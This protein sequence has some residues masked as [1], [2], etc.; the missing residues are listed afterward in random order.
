VS[1]FGKNHLLPAQ[2]KVDAGEVFEAVLAV[3]NVRHVVAAEVCVEIIDLD[4][5]DLYLVRQNNIETAARF[6]AKCRGVS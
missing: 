5:P 6:H 2:H 3:G 1:G 4:R